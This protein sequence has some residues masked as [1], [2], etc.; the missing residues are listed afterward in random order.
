[1]AAG[2]TMAECDVA[3]TVLVDEEHVRVGHTAAGAYANPRELG[4][5]VDLE[6]DGT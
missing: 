2:L 6:P 5:S 4:R 1:M 3:I